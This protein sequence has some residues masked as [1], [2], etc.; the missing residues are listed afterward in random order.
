MSIIRRHL[1]IGCGVGL[2]ASTPRF[3]I[4]TAMQHN[5]KFISTVLFGASPAE[6]LRAI[7]QANFDAV[8][9][10]DSDVP[11]IMGSFEGARKLLAELS[12][13]VT[14]YQLLADFDGAPGTKRD[15]K[16]A[17][18]I[19]LMDRAVALGAPA[20]AVTASTD[21]DCDHTRVAEDLAWLVEEARKR[22]L[23]LGYEPMSWSVS[24]GTLPEAWSTLQ[25]LDTAIIR[26]VVDSYHIFSRGRSAQDLD[27]IPADCVAA[28]QL[29]D[30]KG[31]IL[32][33]QYREAARTRR[34]LPGQGDFPIASLVRKLDQMSYR[35]PIGVEVFNDKLTE[36]RPAT[37]AQEAMRSLNAALSCA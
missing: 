28:V 7:S 5:S 19:S 11:L 4:A 32:P 10:W 36:M 6:T 23:R 20:L 2:I 16:R 22:S 3:V 17:E 13:A 1:L 33:E 9:F 34:L 21:A 14:D 29:G 25:T 15:A 35:G 18:A 26:L 30:A 24:H 37:L 8:E 27:G 31:P 12:L